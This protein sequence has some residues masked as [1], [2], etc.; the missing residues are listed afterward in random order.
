MYLEE[1]LNDDRFKGK[2]KDEINMINESLVKYFKKRE[3][4]IMPCPTNEE[5]ELVMLKRMNLD[6][7]SENFQDEFEVLK[8]KIYESSFD[9]WFENYINEMSK[10]RS[11]ESSKASA[12][13]L[14]YDSKN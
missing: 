1:C 12:D 10:Y 3:C 14:L 6:E 9:V 4:V 13:K 2:N 7:L 8:K 5:R 11:T